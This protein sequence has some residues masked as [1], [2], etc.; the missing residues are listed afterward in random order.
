MRPFFLFLA[1]LEMGLIFWSSSRPGPEG[2]LPH[3]WDKG[4]HLLA[5]LLLGYLWG[6]GLGRP[7]LAVLLAWGY[8]GLDELHQSL[9]PGRE[10]SFGDFLAD[11]AGALLG[12]YL[13]TRGDGGRRRGLTRP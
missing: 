1:L 9:V 8:G 12:V 7:L 4:A 2:G 11:G 13:A 6:R 10:V 5:Y 3:P